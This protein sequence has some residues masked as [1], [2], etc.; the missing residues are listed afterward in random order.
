MSREGP[1]GQVGK[2][3]GLRR[4][5][6]IFLSRAE[7]A[8]TTKSGW[9]QI[10]SRSWRRRVI[11]LA[12][13]ATI[14]GVVGVTPALATFTPGAPSSP[15]NVQP[16]VVSTGTCSNVGSLGA[17]QFKANKVYIDI[18]YV[19]PGGPTITI[20]AAPDWKTFSWTISP[21]W[22]VFDVTVNGFGVSWNHF[23][24]QANGGPRTFDGAL[25]AP[26]LSGEL[27][28]LTSAFFCYS[29]VEVDEMTLSG[30]KFHDENIDGLRGETEEGLGEWTITAT[31]TEGEGS[32][33]TTT[34]GNGEWELSV[35]VGTY[36]VCET[37]QSGWS[38]SYP[39]NSVCGESGAP[40]G[41][42]VSDDASDL[43]FGNYQVT[44]LACGETVDLENGDSTASFT[45]LTGDGSPECEAKVHATE[46]T[47]LDEVVFVPGNEDGGSSSTYSGTITFV[48][49]LQNPIPPLVYDQNVFDGDGPYNPVPTCDEGPF[50]PEGDTWCITGVS[51]VSGGGQL[52]ITWS[53]FGVGD[54]RF[55]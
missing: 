27:R 40:G 52:T 13:V 15:G 55:K 22:E 30:T 10:V 18:T 31:P 42:S 8:T 17:F 37:L 4:Q 24:Y 29:A 32:Y 9:R 54:P 47:D 49:P 46:I 33:S 26:L 34:D 41:H 39:D 23:D 2:W 3:R 7:E 20:D 50:P 1:S 45:R 53:L 12:L 11:V 44:L 48:K 43:D 35:P 5:A 21:G 28:K 6:S 14:V 36:T 16:T 38:Q 25:H 19:I 51:V